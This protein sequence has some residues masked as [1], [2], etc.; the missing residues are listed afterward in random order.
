[1]RLLML[2]L[3]DLYVL[4]KDDFPTYDSIMNLLSAVEAVQL[5]KIYSY[6]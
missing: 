2:C 4:S 6:C 1:M 5:K 3:I